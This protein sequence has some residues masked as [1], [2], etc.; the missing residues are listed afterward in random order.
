MAA[1]NLR[2]IQSELEKIAA[3]LKHPLKDEAG[4]IIEYLSY[5][6]CNPG[7]LADGYCDAEEAG[8]E[9]L[10][11]KYWSALLLRYWYKIFEWMGN[12]SSLGLQPTDF[13]NW[14][15]EALWDAFVYRSWRPLRKDHSDKTKTWKEHPYM[16]NPQYRP[17]DAFAADRSIHFFLA[18]KR[19]KE[20]Q[21][22]NKDKRRGNYQ[23]LSIDS[24]FDEEG[25]YILDVAGLSEKPK[26]Y[27]G[28]QELVNTFLSQNK[29]IEAIV[30]DT[31]CY[32][33]SFKTQTKKVVEQNYDQETGE[34]METKYKSVSHNFDPRRL[35]KCLN[36]VDEDYFKMW[37]TKRYE[38]SDYQ[39]ALKELKSLNNGKL[40]KAV[41]RTLETIKQ[42]PD[43]L[44]CLSQ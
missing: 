23:T 33:E 4:N 5:K 19:G 11:N 20:Y 6:D 43:L 32:G 38:M 24:T 26:V 28:I 9:E 30:V 29:P 37:F 16:N 17:E 25:Y 36:A 42:S 2:Q 21:L 8:N 22:A 18:A 12:S 41:E 44:L 34:M 7:Q 27:D 3:T 1:R 39:P 31:L 10:C 14:L 13:F 40:Y 15:H 35:V